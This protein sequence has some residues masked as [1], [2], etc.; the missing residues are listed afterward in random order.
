MSSFEFPE[1]DAFTTGTVGPKGER[2]F[3]LQATAD[4]TVVSFKLEKQ[5]VSAMAEYLGELL[6]DIPA[7]DIGDA[8]TAPDLVTPVEP[9][10]IVGAMGAAYD[11]GTERII[12]MAEE[13]S[14]EDDE[15]VD[16]D[17]APA[18]SVATFR[19][20]PAQ[21]LAFIERAHDI[22]GAGRPPCPICAR[23]LDHGEDGFCPCWN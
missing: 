21:T 8:P 12:L 17:G 18:G 11:P 2:V 10:W 4:G 7:V 19:L 15:E 14:T 5:Q 23:P 1:V 9:L 6:A 20:T 3:F 13:I 16:E 22:L